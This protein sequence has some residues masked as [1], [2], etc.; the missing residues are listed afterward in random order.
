MLNSLNIGTKVTGAFGIMLLVVLGL[1][2]TAI[3]PRV[4][5]Q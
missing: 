4:R 5:G 2:V 1:G 3:N